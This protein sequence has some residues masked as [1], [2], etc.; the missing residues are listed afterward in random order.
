MKNSKAND[1]SDIQLPR[2]F[3]FAGVH[4]GLKTS[5]LDIT[6]IVCETASTAA[7]VYTQNL[8]HAAS[9]DWNRQITPNSN[10]CAVVI[11]SGNANACTGLQGK[12]DNQQMALTASQS[13]GCSAEQILIL[14]TGVIGQCLPMDCINSGIQTAVSTAGIDPNDFLNAADGILTTDRFRKVHS[15]TISIGDSQGTIAGMAKGAG[16]IGPN[17]ATMLCILMTDWQ[18]TPQL[19]DQT[20]RN[21]VNASFNCISVDGH[22]ST[23]DAVILLSNSQGTPLNGADQTAAFQHALTE[24]CISLARKIPSDGEGASHLIEILVHGT[25]NDADANRVA[26]TIASS[27]LVKTAFTGADPNW[28]RIVSA[29]GYAG[30]SFNLNETSLQLNGHTVYELGQPVPFDTTTV[31]QDLRNNFESKVELCVGTGTGQAT[32]WTSDLT[33]DYVR[34][35]SEYTT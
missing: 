34:L 18:L 28:G 26:R 2:G 19:A 27:A 6:A 32:H 3:R 13:L 23:N 16:M 1:I 7:G 17:M 20:L 4:S 25:T 8:V 12:Q 15:Q 14:S 11:N 5:D 21:A 24:T 30:I 35:N 31:S 29:A 22:T 10:I 33:V 9:I